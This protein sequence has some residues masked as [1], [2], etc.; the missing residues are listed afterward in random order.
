MGSNHFTRALRYAA[1]GAKEG[2]SWWFGVVGGVFLC[3]LLWGVGVMPWASQLLP[4]DPIPQT[5]FITGSFLL[6][7]AFIVFGLRFACYVLF[8]DLIDKYGGFDRFVQYKAPSLY[9]SIPPRR[10][11]LEIVLLFALGLVIYQTTIIERG[12]ST[13]ITQRN[14]SD[15]SFPR[16]TGNFLKRRL[17][18]YETVNA[19]LDADQKNLSSLQSMVLEWPT[20]V[21]NVGIPKYIQQL[22][23]LKSEIMNSRT[24]AI[25]EAAYCGIL[26]SDIKAL[27]T[28]INIASD[29]GPQ[30][31]HCEDVFKSL[32]QNQF[33]LISAID[34]S[35]VAR[36][37]ELK[38]SEYTTLQT[39]LLR[40][41][42]VESEA[43]R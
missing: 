2:S 30:V 31:D 9:R 41:V 25:E 11:M 5:L 19:E 33:P 26:C 42:R 4:Q 21:S 6:S 3:L 43:A 17:H 28:K 14:N 20:H 36:V 7:G 13:L 8:G 29:I 38:I 27:L 35:S 40:R 15:S 32:N 34:L 22:E 24:A 39:E 10:V 18:L 12:I 23:L 16:Y 1:D 37:I